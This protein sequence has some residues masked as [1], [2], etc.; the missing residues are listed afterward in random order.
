MMRISVTL[1][2]EVVDK[3]IKYYP[4]LK[5]VSKADLIRTVVLKHLELLDLIRDRHG[6]N[7]EIA[8]I[9]LREIVVT[10]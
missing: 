4:E 3:L 2:D 5:Y 7:Y 9:R 6:V 1:S 8:T 10:R